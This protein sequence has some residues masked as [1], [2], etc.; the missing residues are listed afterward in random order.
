LNLH[1]ERRADSCMNLKVGDSK[2]ARVALLH[3]AEAIRY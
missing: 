2:I 3:T 1:E